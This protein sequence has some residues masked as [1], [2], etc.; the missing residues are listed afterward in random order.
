[1]GLSHS[2]ETPHG[3]NAEYFHIYKLE[4]Y[5]RDGVTDV[6]VFGYISQ[7]A[8]T[9]GCANIFV[10]STRM[11]GGALTQEEIYNY[12]KTQQLFEGAQDA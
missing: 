3:V 8:R 1:M 12:I 7:N 11:E 4:S 6:T 10:W 2:I 5:P 9:Q